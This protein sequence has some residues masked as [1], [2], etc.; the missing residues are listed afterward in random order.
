MVYTGSKTSILAAGGTLTGTAVTVEVFETEKGTV[1]TSFLTPATLLPGSMYY[2]RI[3]AYNAMGWSSPAL[4][5]LS[6]VTENQPPATVENCE[7]VVFSPTALEVSWMPPAMDGGDT[8]TRY[9]VEWDED[10]TF[11]DSTGTAMVDASEGVPGFVYKI[12]GLT[13]SAKTVARVTAYSSNGYGKAVIA[14]PMYAFDAIQKVAISTTDSGALD[15]D[16]TLTVD[17]GGRTQTTATLYV[18]ALASEV[19]TALQ[20]LDNVGPVLV[21]RA[22]MSTEVDGTTVATNEVSFVYMVTFISDIYNEG[23][24]TTMETDSS[25][26]TVTDYHSGYDPTSTY[27]QSDYRV[28]SG[29][30]NLK[31]SIVTDSSLRVYKRQW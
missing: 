10:E 22:D 13:A 11:D 27:I 18:G 5:L 21:T 20:A 31:I 30:T 17:A 6:T 9:L 23:A 12:T 25:Y 1:P 15:S 24:V 4:G 8:I 16:F 26:V 19:Q 28:P 7:V 29:P 2:V 14:K 3:S